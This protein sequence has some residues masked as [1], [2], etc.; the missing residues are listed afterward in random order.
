MENLYGGYAVPSDLP[1]PSVVMNWQL[2]RILLLTVTATIVFAP[3]AATQDTMTGEVIG[4]VLDRASRTPLAGASVTFLNIA[5]G[6]RREG[7]TTSRGSYVLFHLE[8]GNYTV[9]AEK[10]GYSSFE[11]T[12]ILVPLNQPKLMIPAFELRRLAPAPVGAGFRPRLESFSLRLINVGFNLTEQAQI[13]A[14]PRT[15]SEPGLTSLVSLQDW[16]LRSNFDISLVPSLPLRGGRTFDQLALFAPGVTPAPASSGE[17]PAVGIGVGS[18]GQFVVNG[19]R[20][21]NNNF[22][23][24]GS[25][26]NDEDIGVRRQ[27]FVA[28]VPQSLESIEEFQIMTAGFPAHFGRNSGSMVNAVSRSGQN[29]LHGAIYGFFNDDVLSARNFFDSAFID[30]V[31]AG[32]L[33]GG[34]YAGKDFNHKQYGGVISGPVIA[35]RLFYFASGEQ[36]RGHGMALR[37]FVVPVGGERGLR[38]RGGFV[39]IDELQSF[40]RDRLIDYSSAAGKSILSLY[41]LPNNTAGPFREHNY[42]QAGPFEANSSVFSTKLDW[43]QSRV[44]SVAA[45]YNSTQDESRIPFTGEAINSAI[46]TRTRTQNLSLFANSTTLFW[47]N[48]L[49]VSYGRTRLAFPPENG[50]PLLFGS[51]PIG[52]APDLIREVQTSFGHFGP[53]GVSGPIGQLSILPYSPIGVDVYNFPQGRVDNTYQVSDFV[54]RIGNTHITKAGFD[55]RHSQLNSFTDRNSRPLMIFGYGKVG[56]TCIQ[57]PFC[58]F[59]TLD[60]A[61][62][63]TDLAAFGAPSGLLQALSTDPSADTTIGLRLTQYDFFIQDDWRVRKNLTVNLGVRYELQTVPYETNHRIEKTFGLTPDQFGHLEPTGSAENQ[64]IIRSGNLAFDQALQGLQQF[65]GGRQQIYAADRNNFSPRIGFAWDP[66]GH[67]KTAIHA[68]YS[69]HFD[70]NPGA[71]TSQ[72]RN[73]FPTFV[74]VNLDLNFKPPTGEIVNNPTFFR[75]TPTQTPLVRPGTLNV[76]N[77]TGNAFATGLGTLFNQQPP[78]PTSN[79]SSNGL[80]FT[81]PEKNLRTGY[82]QHFVLSGEHQLGDNWMVSAAYVGTRGQLLPRFKTPNGGLIS[83]PVLLSS[84]DQPFTILDQPPYGGRPTAS[85]GA[86]TVM[87]NSASSSYHAMQLAVLKRL[88]HGLQFRS[89]WT[90]S[91]AIDDVSDM[92]EARGFFALPEDST[93]PGTDRSSA[94][95]DVRHRVTGFLTWSGFR[96][97]KVALTGEFQTGQPYTLNT[98]VDRNGDGNLTDRAGVGRNTSRAAGIRTVDAAITRSFSLGGSRI[99]DARIEVFNVLNHTNLG[100]PV[101]I[102]ESPGFG[103]TFDTQVAARSVRLAAKLTF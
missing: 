6:R 73:V 17:G 80:A 67:G 16:A 71:F 58:P 22:T 29:T 43:Y 36:Q 64:R 49:R 78:N 40:F 47:G 19:L 53:F 83:T 68:G 7:L 72:S 82:A 25:D 61:L 9:R 31:N 1:E 2:E 59:A 42:S 30:S 97:W 54:T 86:F 84:F 63:G 21:R 33:N 32:N 98:V 101:R 56:S 41:P 26:N 92:F 69:V 74:P 96:H 18:V 77:L 87:E 12:G 10:E 99:L 37:H 89:N 20:S 51:S 103:T 24:D 81:L 100:I 38:T 11:R 57:N 39:P 66:V 3:S 60:G 94:N 28:L 5:N 15:E 76:Y 50:S 8:P 23:V 85:L 90:W 91:H 35:N 65:V 14:T 102:L 95:F 27:G 93:K 62:H 52:V 46:G 44:H 45:R 75:F 34:R 48:A 4:S 88:S 79:L 70:A 55:I 13:P